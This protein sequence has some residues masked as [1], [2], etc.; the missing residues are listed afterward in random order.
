MKKKQISSTRRMCYGQPFYA[1]TSQP[2]VYVPP[3]RHSHCANTLLA[4]FLEECWAFLDSSVTSLPGLSS[5][6]NRRCRITLVHLGILFQKAEEHWRPLIRRDT[7]LSEDS[8][9]MF[10]TRCM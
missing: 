7:L 4:Y 9:G 8:I 6:S 3:A 2:F 5:D 10:G 1:V